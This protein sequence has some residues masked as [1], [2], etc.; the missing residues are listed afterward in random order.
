MLRFLV[1]ACSYISLSFKF[2]NSKLSIRILQALVPILVKLLAKPLVVKTT[3]TDEQHKSKSA[4]TFGSRSNSVMLKNTDA[5][6]EKR[7]QSHI[8]TAVDKR[9]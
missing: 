8:Q 3:L 7:L 9:S 5:F 4:A 1:T 2:I 6:L